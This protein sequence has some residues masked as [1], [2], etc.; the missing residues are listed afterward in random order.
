MNGSSDFIIK[1]FDTLKESTDKNERTMQT[2]INQQQILVDT[3]KHMPINEIRKEIQDHIDS[4]KEERNIILDHI[5]KMDFKITK[6]I[7]TVI[8]AFTI[9]TGGY[10]FIRSI[11]D[12][13]ITNTPTHIQQTNP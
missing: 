6:M 10:L 12:H 9:V 2:L 7:I 13:T 1:L 8:V 5:V 4:A 11:V 3:V